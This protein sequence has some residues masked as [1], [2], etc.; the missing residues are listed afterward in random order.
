MIYRPAS[1]RHH[2]SVWL[3]PA[4]LSAALLLPVWFGIRT[5]WGAMTL[6]YELTPL[7]LIITY[8]PRV[9]RIDR[10]LIT[11]VTLHE[12]LTR[13]RRHIG[14]GLPNLKE[15]RFSYAETGAITMF[16][17]STQ[18]LTVVETTA[19]KWGISPANAGEFRRALAEGG[20]GRFDPVAGASPWGVLWTAA[21]PLGI[22][23]GM[24]ALWRY[25]VRMARRLAY[26]L[27]HDALVIHGG[28][29]PVKI[30]YGRI[31]RI[32][33]V[34]PP[35]FPWRSFGV[36]MPGLHWGDFRWS[37]LGG[38]LKL[39]ATRLRPLV[40]IETGRERIGLTPEEPERFMAELERRTS[41]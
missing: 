6:Q 13:G 34:T 27:G 32:S 25:L 24:A 9:E 8:G 12:N 40:L 19:G 3:L 33:I 28:F 10:Q 36:S 26:E 16:A 2:W 23:L 39:Y 29:S 5:V 30:P 20:S 18:P 41:A 35:G 17:A 11:G 37:S 4:I 1:A 21:L 38:S 31:Q 15:G 22:G 7:E 14:T